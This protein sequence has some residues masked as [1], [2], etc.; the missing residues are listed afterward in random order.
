MVVRV[1]ENKAGKSERECQDERNI[2]I[3]NKMVWES[4]ILKGNL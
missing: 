2:A 4:L 1:T 3:L